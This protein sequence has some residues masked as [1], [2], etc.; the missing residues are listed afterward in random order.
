MPGAVDQ[1]F[2][3]TYLSQGCQ[4]QP[5][6]LWA[7]HNNIKKCMVLGSQSKQMPT[8]GSLVVGGDRGCRRS[9]GTLIMNGTS[10]HSSAT[11][12]L[13]HHI[14]PPNIDCIQYP[15]LSEYS[16][17]WMRWDYI[18]TNPVEWGPQIKLNW[19]ITESHTFAYTCPW[20]SYLLFANMEW[21]SPGPPAYKR[22]L[23]WWHCPSHL[24]QAIF[25][26]CIL[27][28]E[29]FNPRAKVFCYFDL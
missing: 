18:L 4:N 2:L 19:V 23:F 24:D 29:L 14:G 5:G 28:K 13:I 8:M 25:K 12:E 6:D 1:K 21:G 11:T 22:F 17:S 3:G 15:K 16:I 27:S 20:A 7:P 10:F 9:M 26:I